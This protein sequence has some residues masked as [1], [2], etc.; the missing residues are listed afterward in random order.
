M[1]HKGQWK[2]LID[3]KQGVNLYQGG[4]YGGNK[5]PQY[6]GANYESQLHSQGTGGF[7][8]TSAVNDQG[9]FIGVTTTT[10]K[11]SNATN[12][13]FKRDGKQSQFDLDG[14]TPGKYS[15]K[16]QQGVNDFH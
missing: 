3:G 6:A 7:E 9:D 13:N 5:P 11:P 4:S 8:G 1:A 15:D 14:Q 2:A 16:V 10:T 12:L